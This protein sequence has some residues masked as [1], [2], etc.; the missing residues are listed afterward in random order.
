MKRQ[1]ILAAV[2]CGLGVSAAGAADWA[3]VAAADAAADTSPQS[4]LVV[5]GQSGDLP[6]GTV[7]DSVIEG[8][9]WPA[10][11][12]ESGDGWVDSSS[13]TVP[14]PCGDGTC[15][16][17]SAG[18]ESFG[19]ESYADQSFGDGY[20]AGTYCGDGYCC[21]GEC[22][23]SDW[24]RV[25]H[26]S[27]WAKGQSDLYRDR[28]RRNSSRFASYMRG[29]FGYFCP[30]G[31]CGK[32]VPLYGKYHMVYAQNPGHTDARDG[33]GF[34]APGTGVHMNVPIAPNVRHTYNYGWGVP[35]SRLTPLRQ[36]T[37]VGPPTDVVHGP[38]W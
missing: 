17:E 15:G 16:D 37:V 20:S 1:N 25:H 30:T 33:Y 18:G 26:L 11:H 14:P 35:S 32:G 6:G 13:Q 22:G 28:N 36:A 9:I 38:R 19:G 7:P 27:G 12:F 4:E 5:R 2:V 21:D 29:K 24:G 31:A 10:G 34:Q 23:G 8:G 3:D